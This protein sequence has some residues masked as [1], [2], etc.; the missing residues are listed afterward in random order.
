MLTFIVGSLVAAEHGG[1]DLGSFPHE[2]SLAVWLKPKELCQT[3]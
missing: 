1:M 2:L 3:Q